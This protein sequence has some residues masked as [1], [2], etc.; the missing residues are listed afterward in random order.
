MSRALKVAVLSALFAAGLAAATAAPAFAQTVTY[1]FSGDLIDADVYDST[2]YNTD[3]GNISG[4]FSIN[5]ANNTVPTLAY[6][7]TSAYQLTN[8]GSFSISGSDVNPSLSNCYYCYGAS[9]GDV[10]LGASFVPSITA[11]Y[12]SSIDFIFPISGGVFST[13]G[14]QHSTYLPEFDPNATDG[15]FYIVG[16]V[17]E[18]VSAAPEPG[19]WALMIA[20]VAMVG[21]M[22]RYSARSRLRP[23]PA[24]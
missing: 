12:T 8:P 22:L 9:A 20:G 15:D 2:L 7:V 18:A 6:T 14:F 5:A 3:V 11:A 17:S 19:A 16:S 4:T 10:V 13:G 23:A 21:G 1:N 24:A